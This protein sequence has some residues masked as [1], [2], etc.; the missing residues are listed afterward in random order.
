MISEH[1]FAS[2]YAS[3]WRSVTPLSDGYWK[4]NNQLINRIAK[5]VASRSPKEIRGL[6]NELA[7][8]AF[9]EMAS[10]PSGGR[11]RLGPVLRAA[12]V[13]AVEYLNRVDPNTGYSAAMLDSDALYEAASISARL[14]RFFVAKRE[15]LLRPNFAGCGI[16]SACEGDVL[17][18][19]C[20][21]EIKAGD[22]GFR[23]ID[24][25]QLLVY[26]ALAY[27]S[28]RLTFDRIGLFNPRTGVCWERSLDEV[29]LAIA[30]VKASDA[31]P[32]LVDQFSVASV[33][34]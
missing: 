31:L 34:R 1:R 27:S 32:A 16:L 21:Y 13:P 15:L 18:R 10:L 30:G 4:T 23:L 9:C 5:P 3:V 8:I 26:S 22:R 29:A 17:Y 11:V 33:S 12:V 20:L 28:G 24:L 25:R 6:V 7:F 2:A 14:L 19:G